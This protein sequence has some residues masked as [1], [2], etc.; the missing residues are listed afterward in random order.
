MHK[1]TAW[2]S[3]SGQSSMELLDIVALLHISSLVD[4]AALGGQRASSRQ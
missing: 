4:M 2:L 3:Q 1:V